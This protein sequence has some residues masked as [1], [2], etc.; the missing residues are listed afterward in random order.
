MSNLLNSDL[1]LPRNPIPNFTPNPYLYL[2]P[3][4]KKESNSSHQTEAFCY[5]PCPALATFIIQGNT[6]SAAEPDTSG[7][8]SIEPF[9]LTYSLRQ[10]YPPL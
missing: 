8:R 3:V 10:L 4:H 5:L 7:L 1:Q 6:C 2:S 9:F